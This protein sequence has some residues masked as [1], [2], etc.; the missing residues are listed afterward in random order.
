MKEN[1]PGPDGSASGAGA[2]Q[3]SLVIEDPKPGATVGMNEEISGRLESEGWPVIFVQAD[4]PGQPWWCQAP[5]TR[6]EGGKFSAKVIFGDDLTPSGMKFR[7]AG[8]VTRTHDEALKFNIGS[9]YPSLP[10]GFPQSVEL[11][12]THQ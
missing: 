4:I 12:V 10:D 8:I 5:I 2:R 9:K 3:P 1:R 7:V 11:V 6:V